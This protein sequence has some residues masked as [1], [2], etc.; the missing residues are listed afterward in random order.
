MFNTLF[1]MP[2]SNAFGLWFRHTNPWHR[3]PNIVVTRHSLRLRILFSY[4]TVARGMR[5]YWSQIVLLLFSICLMWY[6]ASSLS[7]PKS[8]RKNAFPIISPIDAIFLGPCIAIVMACGV[9]LLFVLS[10]CSNIQPMEHFD[11]SVCDGAAS[12]EDKI[13][14]AELQVRKLITRADA[15]TEGNLGN[16]GQLQPRLVADAL[17]K[18]RSDAGGPLIDCSPGH[19]GDFENRLTR[20]ERTLQAF[21]EP[22]FKQDASA[23]NTCEG[24][25][26]FAGV[27]APP[28][29]EE[30]IAAILSLIQ[31]QQ[32]KY[33]KPIDDK[34]AALQRHEVS[35]CDKSKASSAFSP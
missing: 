9:F 28:S 15:F 3:F 26:G 30:R 5:L 33:L 8:D 4:P 23:S 18:T 13:T 29:N 14:C 6:G 19:T 31:H 2:N 27:V 11:S 1:E 10:F 34:V 24:F 7:I 32:T 12:M 25:G 20:L 17:G 22:I 21:T 35:D 16:D